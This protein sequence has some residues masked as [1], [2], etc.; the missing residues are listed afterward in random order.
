MWDN[1]VSNTHGIMDVNVQDA[2]RHEVVKLK[3]RVQLGNN[4]QLCSQEIFLD[5]PKLKKLPTRW[6]V[7]FIQL[8]DRISSYCITEKAG[9][10]EYE[11]FL[12]PARGKINVMT[13][14]IRDLS[15]TRKWKPTIFKDAAFS[16]MAVTSNKSKESKIASAQVIQN[17]VVIGRNPSTVKKRK[18]ER[19]SEEENK[20]KKPRIDK[21]Q[22]EKNDGKK[23]NLDDI[24]SEDTDTEA[25]EQNDSVN[26]PKVRIN[27]IANDEEKKRVPNSESNDNAKEESSFILNIEDNEFEAV[28][29]FSE[30]DHEAKANERVE[31]KERDI[32]TRRNKERTSNTVRIDSQKSKENLVEKLESST[33]TTKT[34]DLPSSYE[35]LLT[36]LKLCSEEFGSSERGPYDSRIDTFKAEYLKLSTEEEKA[37]MILKIIRD[38]GNGVPAV[39]EL[40]NAIDSRLTSNVPHQETI[41]TDDDILCGTTKEAKHHTGTKFYE[42]LTETLFEKFYQKL[43]LPRMKTNL[44]REVNNLLKN[45]GYRFFK[46]VKGKEEWHELPA[47]EVKQKI[48]SRFSHLS[49]KY[50]K[51]K[52]EPPVMVEGAQ[53]NVLEEGVEDNALSEAREKDVV[54]GRGSNAQERGGNKPFYKGICGR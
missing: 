48:S 35:D 46:Q 38:I 37:R 5:E 4:Y 11:D 17:P 53:I 14:T 32:T 43:T 33:L 24:N 12:K 40:L 20:N 7:A 1:E 21:Q 31:S 2:E 26:D 19:N 44:L 47:A 54:L 29:D 39:S 13:E 18:N 52:L 41:Y 42:K 22:E 8:F 49:E 15:K 51:V 34:N 6:Y 27:L 28:D 10:S 9:I 50:S 25:T 3:Y 36:T 45:Q 30:D 16:D 23:I